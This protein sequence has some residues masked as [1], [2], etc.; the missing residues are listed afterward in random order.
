MAPRG[1]D[2]DSRSTART[3][4]VVRAGTPA[5]AAHRR[6]PTCSCRTIRGGRDRRSRRRLRAAADGRSRIRRGGRRARRLARHGGA[7][8]RRGGERHGA[9]VRR[10]ARRTWSSAI[11]PSIGPCCYE[12]G[13]ELVDAF[14]AA[15]HER[16][17]IDRWFSTPAAAARVARTRPQLR[18]DV[19][20]AN[21]DQLM[22]AGVP[23]GQ[24]HC[25]GC[26]P[27]CTSTC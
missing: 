9:G 20:G 10:A 15:G 7:S 27:R 11:G 17:L 6:R 19:A 12:V 4:V 21:R 24:I 8:G 25:R 18:L 1:R 14:A 5:P 23:E 22:L 2:G 13:S 16:H 3:V 26:A